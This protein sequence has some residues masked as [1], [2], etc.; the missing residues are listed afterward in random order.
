MNPKNNIFKST[1]VDKSQYENIF[2][3]INDGLD[4]KPS[5][6]LSKSTKTDEK[7][8][9]EEEL[10][11]VEQLCRLKK[12][13][14]KNNEKNKKIIFP[15]KNIQKIESSCHITGRSIKQLK[16][17]IYLGDKKINKLSIVLYK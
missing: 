1:Q 8:F 9:S 12:I 15:I 11:V 16:K 10:V 6:D 5:D 17:P 14:K 3:Q 13:P 7:K 2:K 4:E